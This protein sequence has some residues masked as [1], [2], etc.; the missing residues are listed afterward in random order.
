MSN[1]KEIIL[2]EHVV[3]LIKSS[4]K[5]L[6]QLRAQMLPLEEKFKLINQGFSKMIS[7]ICLQENVDLEKSTLTFED[8]FK[9]IVVTSNEKVETPAKK[10]ATRKKI[11]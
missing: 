6:E 1:V 3:E 5:E 9:K 10:K 7:G 2:N 11:N 8:D 4:Q